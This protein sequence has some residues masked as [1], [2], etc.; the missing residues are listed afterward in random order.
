MKN[1]F[2]EYLLS[3][4][5]KDLFLTRAMNVIEFYKKHITDN[6]DDIFVTDY[7]DEQNVRHYDNLWL[8]NKTYC[9]EAKQF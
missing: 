7:L 8:F 1:S 5:I 6:V 3:I 9:M 4:G 2:E